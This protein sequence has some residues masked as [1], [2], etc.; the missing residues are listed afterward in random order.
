MRR[1]Y[2]TLFSKLQGLLKIFYQIRK[3]FNFRH[4]IMVFRLLFLALF[5]FL[6]KIL[7]K[8]EKFMFTKTVI[9]DIIVK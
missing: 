3:F 9:C 2:T 1:Y 5:I 8:D 7:L 6:R 4:L